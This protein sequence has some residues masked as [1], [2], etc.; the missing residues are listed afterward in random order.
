MEQK[1]HSVLVGNSTNY[2]IEQYIAGLKI[3]GIALNKKAITK[4]TVIDIPIG[5]Y[6]PTQTVVQDQPTQ[7]E[8]KYARNVFLIVRKDI[9]K[10]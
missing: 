3:N 4:K 9:I 6:E 1:K 5:S 10:A 8:E 2:L 7:T